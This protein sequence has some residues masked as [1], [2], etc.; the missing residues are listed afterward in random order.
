MR[1]YEFVWI[2]EGDV[3]YNWRQTTISAPAPSI[4]LCRPGAVDFFR[5]DPDRRTRYAYFHFDILSSPDD[6]PA[7]EDWPLARPLEDGSILPPLIRH[8]LAWAGRGN[9]RQIELTMLH[10]LTAFVTG[11]TATGELPRQMIPESV[12]RV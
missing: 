3:E 9:A 4:V 12:E 11:E 6:W 1:E 2:T 7:M 8:L 5:F 10:I